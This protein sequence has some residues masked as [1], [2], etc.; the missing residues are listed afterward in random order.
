MESKVER[1]VDQIYKSGIEKAEKEADDILVTA[2]QKAGEI[3]KE[4]ADRAAKIK[5]EAELEADQLKKNTE[6]EIRLASTQA[7]S[8]LRQEIKDLIHTKTLEKP[9][10][11][12][13][14]DSA[15]LKELILEIARSW[16]GSDI[17]L[18]IPES[19]QNELVSAIRTAVEK[20]MAGLEIHTSGKAGFVIQKKDEGFEIDFTDEA[21]L[22]YFGSFVKEQT[23]R[24]LESTGS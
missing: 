24:Y 21:F 11:E 9:V 22:S 18:T 3:E 4:A 20:N 1:L 5:K 17:S 7:L 15:F 16:K 14:L 6:A 12:M 2:R 10:K 8:K 13:S 23:A 19:K